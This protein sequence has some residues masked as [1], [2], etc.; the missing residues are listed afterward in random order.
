MQSVNKQNMRAAIN[1][2]CGSNCRKN[3]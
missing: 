2:Y 1:C 3:G